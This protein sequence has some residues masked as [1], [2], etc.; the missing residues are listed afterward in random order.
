[1]DVNILAWSV[2][3]FQLFLLI[4]MRVAFI[5]FMMP[6]LGTRNIPVLAKAGLT[7]TVG[8]I[9]LPVVEI[10]PTVFPSEPL[11]FLSLMF[12]EA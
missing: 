11:Q 12:F 6:L 2:Q 8:L 4:V 5:L 3:Q 10:R 1:M 7:L 9:L